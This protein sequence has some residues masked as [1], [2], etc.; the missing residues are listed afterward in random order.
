MLW[1]PFPRACCQS[2]RVRGGCSRLRWRSSTRSGRS[3]WDGSRRGRRSGSS[4]CNDRR[5]GCRGWD[6]SL[7]RR[8]RRCD[9]RDN[10]LRRRDDRRG[11]C[12][13]WDRS[14][15]WRSGGC[16]VRRSRWNSNLHRCR[17]GRSGSVYLVG[18]RARRGSLCK[19]QRA[20]QGRYN[21]Q[22]KYFLHKIL[23]GASPCGGANFRLGFD[24][25]SDSQI[26]SNPCAF[27]APRPEQLE[28]PG[29]TT[30]PY[31]IRIRLSDP[32]RSHLERG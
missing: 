17:S 28:L 5:S 26:E 3:G 19:P 20:Q 9:R 32:N 15:R 4:R 12:S 8:S 16:S 10:R 23:R 2:R 14:R 27:R 30:Q 6:G 18:S 29:G 25:A 21:D 31:S 7:S 11:R 1:R 22:Q 13:R 24:R